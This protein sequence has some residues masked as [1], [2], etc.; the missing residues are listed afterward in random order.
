MYTEIYNNVLPLRLEVEKLK[1]AAVEVME[2]KE[3]VDREVAELEESIIQ[4][5]ARRKRALLRQDRVS[6]SVFVISSYNLTLSPSPTNKTNRYKTDYA[7]LIRSV[8]I[9]KGEMEKVNE[10]V[11]RAE[12]LLLSLRGEKVRWADN[13][14]G[15]EEGL[16]TV[17]G[18]ALLSSAFLTYSGYHPHRT[19][20][21]LKLLWKSS[22]EEFRIVHRLGLGIVEYLSVGSQR[23]KWNASFGLPDD[24]LCV[25]VS[26]FVNFPAEFIVRSF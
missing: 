26:E 13:V 5:V 9:I 8:E 14:T 7:S 20:E 11:V 19:R 2:K 12:D 4:Y 22:L 10:K 18:D 16:S 3:E 24:N 15:F 21:K 25:E 1:V 23:L 17:V 6:R